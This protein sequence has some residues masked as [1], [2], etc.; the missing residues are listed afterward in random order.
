MPTGICRRQT[1]RGWTTNAWPHPPPVAN[2]QIDIDYTSK[3]G[4]KHI[5]RVA[6]AKD[7]LSTG[8]KAIP[9]RVSLFVI[10][11]AAKETLDPEAPS[12]TVVPISPERIKLGTWGHLQP[13]EE[14]VIQVPEGN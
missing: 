6:Q 2:E 14:N 12:P 13:V 7:T 11:F 3:E 8:N 1:S 9:G 5:R 4:D 10:K